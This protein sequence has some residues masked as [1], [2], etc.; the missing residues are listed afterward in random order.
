MVRLFGQTTIY[1]GELGDVS[2]ES[3]TVQAAY[4]P[5]GNYKKL[6]IA[7]EDIQSIHLAR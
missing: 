5:A 4:P 7:K 2:P 3:L 6:K 1:R